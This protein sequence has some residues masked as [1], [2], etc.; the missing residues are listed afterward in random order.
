M[1]EVLTKSFREFFKT[2]IISYCIK[3]RQIGM[4]RTIQV[5]MSE[6]AL[7]VGQNHVGTVS[8]RNCLSPSARAVFVCIYSCLRKFLSRVPEALGGDEL[9]SSLT[10]SAAAYLRGSPVPTRLPN[11]VATP[12]LPHMD[13]IKDPVLKHLIDKLHPPLEKDGFSLKLDPVQYGV[14]LILTDP[15]LPDDKGMPATARGVLYHSAKKKRVSWVPEGK[16]DAVLV[17]LLTDRVR[18]LIGERHETVAAKDP[19]ISAAERGLASWVGTDE[20][21]KG[22]IFGSLIV[23]GFIADPV[24]AREL[25]AAGVRDSKDLSKQEILRI[26]SL[27]DKEWPDRCLLVAPSTKRYNE[28]YASF[29]QRGGINGV[30]GWAH[31]AAI[32]DSLERAHP[33]EAAVIDRFGGEGRVKANLG[34]PAGKLKLIF[35]PRAE[36]NPAVAA[37]AILAR[38]R[39][40]RSLDSMAQVLGWRPHP[41]AN[42]PAMSDLHRLYKEHKD[43]LPDFVKMHFRP[44]QALNFP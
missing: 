29:Q 21:G 11:A 18:A 34:G 28:L 23:G 13:E 12:I 7:R 5:A 6:K 17:K 1:I 22:D 30:L 44:V 43:R 4:F 16:G 25:T 10:C 33:I 37:G 32:R 27:L 41:G 8:P 42:G 20:A 31:A 19:E 38:A 35:R 9:T 2:K 40:E 26:A 39:F 3:R 14:R 24:I 36:S 15:N